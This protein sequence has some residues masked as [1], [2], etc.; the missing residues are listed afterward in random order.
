LAGGVAGLTVV[1]VLPQGA[2]SLLLEN[3]APLPQQAPGESSIAFFSVS[4][5]AVCCWIHSITSCYRAVC[6]AFS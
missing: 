3:A 2:M 1:E 4:M 5:L 6:G